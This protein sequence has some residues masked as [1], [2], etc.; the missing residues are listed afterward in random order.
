METQARVDFLTRWRLFH[1]LKNERVLRVTAEHELEQGPF[2]MTPGK[3]NDKVVHHS[4]AGS[5]LH[6][7]NMSSVV[8]S[9]L[10]SPEDQNLQ[11]Q[12]IRRLGEAENWII[13]NGQLQCFPSETLGKGG[14]GSVVR[15]R[16]LHMDV[17]VKVSRHP[18]LNISSLAPELRILRKLC[19][20]RIVMFFGACILEDKGIL[21]VV[22]LI[23]GPKTCDRRLA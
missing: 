15:G 2:S 9:P 6:S 10:L 18:Q 12:A 16:Y 1:D 13:T 5:E 3:T 8:F 14:F 22:E 11:L 7:D 21:L 17:A 4:D 19:H 23:T 20:P